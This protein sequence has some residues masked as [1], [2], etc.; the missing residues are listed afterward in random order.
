MP[1]RPIPPGGAR[2]L[3]GRLVVVDRGPAAKGP[4]AFNHGTV[5]RPDH[6]Q[7]LNFNGRTITPVGRSDVRPQ[8]F[9]AARG[10][11]PGS[12][13][14][15]SGTFP[16]VG[17]RPTVNSTYLSGNNSSRGA[18]NQYTRPPQP[19]P[20]PQRQVTPPQGVTQRLP[21]TM[22]QRPNIAYPPAQSYNQRSMYEARPTPT[23]HYS[24]PP[25]PHYSAPPPHYSAPPPQPH[26]SAPPQAQHQ[27]AP[28]PRR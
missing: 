22:N 23:T 25:P 1:I 15:L 14:V 9:A 13:A 3:P 5:P 21:Q 18:Q 20:Q 11:A 19:Q 2:P 26:Y 10:T 12:R 4:W 28:G 8:A 6:Q 17:P 27:S 16:A 24:A 7:A